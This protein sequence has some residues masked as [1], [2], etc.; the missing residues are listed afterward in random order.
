LP[1]AFN[2]DRNLRV[3]NVEAA[4]LVVSATVNSYTRDAASYTGDQAVSAYKL[5]VTA[6]VDANDQVRDE[7]FYSGSAAVTV[8]YDPNART[9]EQAATE[10][11]SKLAA[12]IVR[13]ILIA[14]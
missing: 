14:W 11:I 7:T 12:E 5:T 3:T 8:T 9:E 10:A 2:S 4:N 1:K 6:Q 13:Q